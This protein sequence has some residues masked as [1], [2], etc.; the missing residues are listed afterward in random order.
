MTAESAEELIGSDVIDLAAFGQPYISNPD[1]VGRLRTGAPLTPPDRTTYF[2]GD[3]TGYTDYPAAT[4]S[5]A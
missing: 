1:L 5:G 3:A 4:P 2:G